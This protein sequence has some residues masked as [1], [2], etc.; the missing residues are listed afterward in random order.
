MAQRF[1][2]ITSAVNAVIKHDDSGAFEFLFNAFY[3]KLMRVGLF[4]LGKES[5]AQ[6][7]VSEVFYK[8]WSNRNKLAKVETLENY[9]FTMIK[10]HC[11]GI[12][13]S[14]KKVIFDENIMEFNQKIVLENPESKLISEEFIK[15]Y[16]SKIQELPPRCKV[17]YLMIKEDGLKYKEAA[18]I[19][20][21]SV[22]T[23]ENQ[24]TK[25]VS[26]IRKCLNNYQEYHTKFDKPEIL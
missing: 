8:L 6:D 11:L 9:L 2:D 22:K 10:N 4:Y 7:A 26:H 25:A 1:F 13:R 19:L 21:I 15:F 5:N 20:N 18:D 3:D 16:N 12:I 14:N 17:I 24:M 23:I